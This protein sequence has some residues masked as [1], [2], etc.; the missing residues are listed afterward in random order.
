[1]N[2]APLIELTRNGIS[3][4]LH[5]GALAVTDTQGR[6]VAQ[7]GNPHWLC[8]TRSTLKALQALPLVQSGGVQQLGLTSKELAL[9]CA[10]HNGGDMHLEQVDSILKKAGNTYQQLRCGCHVPYRFSFNDKPLPDGFAVD[11][12]HHNCSGK[13]S[14]FLAYCSLHDVPKE[15]Y[16]ELDHPLQQ[17]I[18]KVVADVTGVAAEDMGVGVDGCSAPN[19]A[20]PLSNLARSYARLA[21][22]EVDDVYGASLKLLGDAM[23]AHPEL[24][25]GTGRSDADFMRVGRGDW[26]TKVGADGVQVIGSRSRGQ[27]L[28]LKI[29]DGNK[30]ALFAAT[31]EALDQLGWLDATQ[32]EELHVWRAQSL[33]NIKGLNVGERRSVF[34]LQFA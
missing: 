17:Q 19:F 34:K 25:S 10:S 7:V 33:N 27:A 18:R 21:K 26:V 8:F 14:G 5:L 28:A 1:M 11:E 29:A 2:F 9:L 4:C 20:V 6:L 12:R 3:E 32:R 31:V 24:V 16:T 22:P 23:T 13:H 30:V 15:T